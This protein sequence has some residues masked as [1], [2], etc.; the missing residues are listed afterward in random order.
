[1]PQIVN[2][3][4]TTTYT[5]DEGRA[6]ILTFYDE[7]G[8][9]VFAHFWVSWVEEKREG[10]DIYQ[11]DLCERIIGNFLA[12]FWVDREGEETY[13]HLNVDADDA[14][15][16]YIDELRGHL[17]YGTQVVDPEEDLVRFMEC[18]F[19]WE[20]GRT[21]PL[22]FRFDCYLDGGPEVVIDWGDGQKVKVDQSSGFPIDLGQGTI[23]KFGDSTYFQIDKTYQSTGTYKITVDIYGALDDKEVQLDPTGG[24]MDTWTFFFNCY[25]WPG[26]K[27]INFVE[28]YLMRTITF[29]NLDDVQSNTPLSTIT[30]LAA[31]KNL[32]GF[33]IDTRSIDLKTLILSDCLGLWDIDLNKSQSISTLLMNNCSRL[34]SIDLTETMLETKENLCINFANFLPKANSKYQECEIVID[35]Q[36]TGFTNN[37][38]AAI[39][40]K[41]WTISE[42]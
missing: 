18:D 24:V 41:G 30:N 20:Y 29:S 25:N 36:A 37:V 22:S 1:M 31:N 16:Y 28:N 4:T 10:T 7:K 39:T 23:V 9:G 27:N 38:R 3:P 34:R 21:I 13:G 19:V 2:I 5:V 12:T 35:N 15:N 6:S 32:H 8:D 33:T 17:M 40:T 42:K 14:Y 11:G 26:M